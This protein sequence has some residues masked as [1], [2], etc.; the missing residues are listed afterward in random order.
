MHKMMRPSDVENLIDE[1]RTNR[2][3][4]DTGG[5]RYLSLCPPPLTAAARA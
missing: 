1:K 2:I 3:G 4:N 5:S